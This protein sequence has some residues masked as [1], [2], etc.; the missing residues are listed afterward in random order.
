MAIT[1]CTTDYKCSQQTFVNSIL[2]FVNDNSV[3]DNHQ[4]II[5]GLISSST[6]FLAAVLAVST[7]SIT[8]I[9]FL[10]KTKA[11]IR[12]EL[13]ILK[14]SKKDT[15]VYEDINVFQANT[16]AINVNDNVAYTNMVISMQK[17]V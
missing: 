5:R 13:S 6:L 10:A 4:S 9:L 3:C 14:D 16:Q 7:V 11:K 17:P 1:E 15:A 8:T 2:G 12:N